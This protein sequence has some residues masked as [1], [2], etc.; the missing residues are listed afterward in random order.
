MTLA[1]VL[2]E[3]FRWQPVEG[4]NPPWVAVQ[5]FPGHHHESMREPVH[6]QGNMGICRQCPVRV[7]FGVTGKIGN[8]HSK[9]RSMG[10]ERVG[11]GTPTECARMEDVRFKSDGVLHIVCGVVVQPLHIPLRYTR[12]KLTEASVEVT[13]IVI[14]RPTVGVTVGI[15]E[16]PK[17][18]ARAV[19]HFRI[20]DDI[21]A[22]SASHA[23]DSGPDGR[24]RPRDLH[25]TYSLFDVSVV[26]PPEEVSGLAS[27]K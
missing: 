23:N 11:I 6:G 17:S 27:G 7:V 16:L 24:Q 19:E 13:A 10:L 21:Q 15:S 12:S 18:L 8:I 2:V 22:R 4:F 26:V 20:T 14:R 3:I 9:R 1:A 5:I 25:S